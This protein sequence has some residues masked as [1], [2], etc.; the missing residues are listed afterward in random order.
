MD[1]TNAL[2]TKVGQMSLE[3]NQTSMD[4]ASASELPKAQSSQLREPERAG[5]HG[6]D[7]MLAEADVTPFLDRPNYV[8]SVETRKCSNNSCDQGLFLTKD[9]KAGELLFCEKAFS[10]IELSENTPQ[11]IILM[12]MGEDVN[13]NSGDQKYF[14]D[15]L[16]FDCVDKLD[17]NPSL[18][19]SFMELDS[20]STGSDQMT[21]R[22]VSRRAVITYQE[23]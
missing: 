12:I 20:E 23:C 6:F 10:S 4:T 22:C 18:V 1:N 21:A 2:D 8:G 16:A 7:G 3:N 11:D 9:V 14:Y 17:R 15:K 5:D 13:I 19:P